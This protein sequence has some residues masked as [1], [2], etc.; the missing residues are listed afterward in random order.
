[1]R[2]GLEELKDHLLRIQT[3]AF[4]PDWYL[5]KWLPPSVCTYFLNNAIE[6]FPRSI[7]WGVGV[8]GRCHVNALEYAMGNREATPFFGFQ[9]CDMWAG[10][11]ATWEVHSW[12]VLPDGSMGSTGVKGHPILPS[13]GHRK[14]PASVMLP[15]MLPRRAPVRP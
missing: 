4:E 9:Y 7:Q 3:G 1:M 15:L 10:E 5:E 6:V 8:P 13:L 14:F 12:I 2:T 11:G